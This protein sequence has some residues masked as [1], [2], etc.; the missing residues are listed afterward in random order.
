M[1]NFAIAALIASVSA[2]DSALD[3]LTEM[4][5]NGAQE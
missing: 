1:K 2:Q 3:F 5:I 4:A